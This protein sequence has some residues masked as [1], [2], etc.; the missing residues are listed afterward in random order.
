MLKIIAFRYRLHVTH[1]NK[2]ELR[3]RECAAQGSSLPE[4]WIGKAQ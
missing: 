2:R 1:P 3:A 4:A